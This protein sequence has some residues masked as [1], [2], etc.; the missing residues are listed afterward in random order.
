MTRGTRQVAA[1]GALVVWVVATVAAATAF[2][3]T[4]ASATVDCA[5]GSGAAL[6]SPRAFAGVTMFGGRALLKNG[7]ARNVLRR[8]SRPSIAFTASTP[9]CASP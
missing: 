7:C 8:P 6:M 2:G 5:L 3:T 4:P 9:R 1:A